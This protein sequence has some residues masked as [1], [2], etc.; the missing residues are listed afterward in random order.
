M[1]QYILLL[2]VILNIV[3]LTINKFLT[4]EIGLGYNYDIGIGKVIEKLPPSDFGNP[5][6]VVESNTCN[7]KKINCVAANSDKCETTKKLRIVSGVL[8]V[9]LTV[10]L[11]VA[12]FYKK[13]NLVSILLLLTFLIINII[14]TNY[15]TPIIKCVTSEQD[16]RKAIKLDISYW[17]NI[18]TILV[19]SFLLVYYILK[20][21]KHRL[22]S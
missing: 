14:I 2:I 4:L 6:G 1:E 20:L 9:L 8:T 5:S 12:I 17:L 13:F 18:A 15:F 7:Y 22:S 21:Y 16:Y 11:T 10:L 19:G 3:S